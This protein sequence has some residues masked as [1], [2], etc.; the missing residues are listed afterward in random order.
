M[1]TLFESFLPRSRLV[2]L[3]LGLVLLAMC[4]ML[5]Y[6][7]SSDGASI[8]S[9]S[10]LTG[11]SA[12]ESPGARRTQDTR[13]AKFRHPAAIR[14]EQNRNG[15]AVIG[16]ASGYGTN[17]HKNFAGTLRKS[18]FKG[19]IVIAVEH[20]IKGKENGRVFEYLE[21]LDVVLYPVQ[22]N[23]GGGMKVKSREQGCLW[24]GLDGKTTDPS[25]IERPIALIRY[26]V[27]LALAEMYY[28]NAWIL[29]SDYRDVFFQDDPFKFV[30]AS[31]P[32]GEKPLWVFE[33]D[34]RSQTMGSCPFNRGWVTSCW[35]KHA[36]DQFEKDPIRCSGDSMGTQEAI[37]IYNQVMIKEME[38]KKCHAFGQDQGYHN[39]LIL[40]GAFQIAGATLKSWYRGDGPVNTVGLLDQLFN[41]RSSASLKKLGYLR[42]DGMIMNNDNTTISPCIHQWDRFQK[43]MHAF[44]GKRGYTR[45]EAKEFGRQRAEEQKQL[46]V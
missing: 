35:G 25:G 18:G 27:Y 9:A 40:S 32:A 39:Y 15:P 8:V 36:V 41:P 43:E 44:V 28:P 31:V 19:D 45:E 46:T 21:D 26:N 30:P 20:D 29:L 7:Y 12:G 6:S 14:G 33:E 4:G 10:M 2:R 42:E 23:C 13:P 5:H 11:L 24:T 34:K 38:E 3:V 17:T 16:M 37:V 22:V 1:A